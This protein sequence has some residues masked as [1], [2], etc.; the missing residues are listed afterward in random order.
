M[1]SKREIER[2]RRVYENVYACGD[3]R[4]DEA[5]PGNAAI[6]AERRRA[7][8][9]LLARHGFLPLEPRRVL[10]IGCG[11]GGVL[12]GLR[13]FGAAAENLHGVDLVSEAIEEARNRHPHIHFQLAN[14]E[15]LE[16]PEAH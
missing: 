14:A 6:Y 2:I 13:E 9:R 15:A 8:E 1:A 3:P 10:E 12:A 5:V 7:V 4:W 11:V 16:F